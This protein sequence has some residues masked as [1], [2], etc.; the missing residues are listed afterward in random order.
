[1]PFAGV[2]DNSR[3]RADGGTFHRAQRIEM[4]AGI[5]LPKAVIYTHMFHEFLPYTIVGTL[6]IPRCYWQVWSEKQPALVSML[7]NL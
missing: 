4:D 6:I 5:S 7:E 1:M 2:T 3:V